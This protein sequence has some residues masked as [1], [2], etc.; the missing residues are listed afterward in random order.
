VDG[1][2]RTAAC[3]LYPEDATAAE[4]RAT[5]GGDAGDGRDRE[6]EDE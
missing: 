2:E 5:H 3:L 6:A 1:A 4:A